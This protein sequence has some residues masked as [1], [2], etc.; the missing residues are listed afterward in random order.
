M[1]FTYFVKPVTLVGM[2]TTLPGFFAAV[3]IA[4]CALLAAAC[5]PGP[6][7]ICW[8]ILIGMLFGNLLPALPVLDGGLGFA[9]KRILPVAIALMG[10]ELELHALGELGGTAFL[11]VLPPMLLSIGCA[12]WIGRMLKLP[13]SAA[14]VLGI[15][16]S[17]CGSSAILA[18]APAVKAEK[19]EVAVAVA[20]VNL[21]GTIG[22]FLLP[23][24]AGI[25]AL[26][27]QNTAYL[28]GG[29]LQAIGQVVASG[30]SVS[31]SVGQSAVVV[32]ML[33]VL[34]IGPIVM[35]L[36]LVF[37]SGS[38]GEG[39]RKKYIPGYILGFIIFAVLASVF[40]GDTIVLPHVRSAAKLFM[41][42]AMAAVGFRIRFR[43][44]AVHGVKAVGLVAVLSLLQTGAILLLLVWL[45]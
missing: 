28:I 35:I 41:V 23:I 19:Q 1:N 20:A 17:V 8:A 24:L 22:L 2:K 16:N 44:L 42:V 14:L 13:L 38:R 12:I 21:M 4:A 31:D 45:T 11:I 43:S 33:R 18:A 10:A 15:G 40:Q 30:F 27:E 3:L 39:R 5:F 6:G 26:P 36:H 7:A 25:L 9:E 37:H 29:S 32:K 34:M